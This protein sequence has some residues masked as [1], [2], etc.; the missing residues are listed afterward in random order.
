MANEEDGYV[1]AHWAKNGRDVW[2]QVSH[3]EDGTDQALSFAVVDLGEEDFGKALDDACRVTLRGVTFEFNKATL[4]P[5][6]ELTLSRVAKALQARKA[7]ALEVAGHTDSQGSDAYNQKLSEARAAA[8]AAWLTAHG[9]A[10]DRLSAKGYGE[11]RPI[12]DNGTDEGR[13]QN[14]RVELGCVK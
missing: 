10:K 12:A 6:S 14:R 7:L 5:E 13:A 11:T 4:A 9:V 8:V 3:R 2:L 1:Q